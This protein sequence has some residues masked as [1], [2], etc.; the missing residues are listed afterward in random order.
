MGSM[1]EGAAGCRGVRHGCGGESLGRGGRRG[2]GWP[3]VGAATRAGGVNVGGCMA[4]YV[5]RLRSGWNGAWANDVASACARGQGKAGAWA[6]GKDGSMSV[7][8]HGHTT[9][10]D[11]P[12]MARGH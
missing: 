1:T 10:C 8:G 4:D 12:L 3:V 11:K 9:A 5:R 7:D 2:G 6:G